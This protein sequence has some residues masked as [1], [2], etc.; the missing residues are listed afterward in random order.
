MRARKR[1]ALSAAAWLL[2]T[3]FIRR[4]LEPVDFVFVCHPRD[5]VDIGKRFPS[6][7]YFPETL[8]VRL[9]DKLWP[10]PVCPLEFVLANGS[11]CVGVMIAVPSTAQML[12]ADRERAKKKFLSAV[13][14]A[15]RMGAKIVCLGGLSGSLTDGGQFILS[16][17]VKC[18]VTTGHSFTVAT[19]I[20]TIRKACET[21]HLRLNEARLAVVG[22]CGSIGAACCRWLLREEKINQLIL[23][24]LKEEALAKLKGELA[25][26]QGLTLRISTDLNSLQDADI[27][28]VAT[29]NPNL[30][31]QP[32]HL[33]SGSIVIDDAQP[34]NVSPAGLNTKGILLAWGGVR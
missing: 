29:N 18:N 32:D 22:A 10:I 20:E 6:V 9:F 30:I 31:I 14:L 34:P 5:V 8:I 33:R 21:R 13:Q 24:D 7:K 26:D 27:V 4:N 28:V 25:G 15:D 17:G 1:L 19:L 11:R 2:P 12:L 3:M 23:I 16:K